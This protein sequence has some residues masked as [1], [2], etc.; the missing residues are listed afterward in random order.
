MSE[1]LSTTI[2]LHGFEKTWSQSYQIGK[3]RFHLSLLHSSEALYMQGLITLDNG[4]Y[5]SE[6][7]SV[8]IFDSDEQDLIEADVSELGRFTLLAPWVSEYLIYLNVRQD[9]FFIDKLIIT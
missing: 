2:R 7:A 9:Q 3:Y 1:T 6:K 8:S 4:L 5:L